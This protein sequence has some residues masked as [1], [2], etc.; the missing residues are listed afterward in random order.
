MLLPREWSVHNPL[1]S[2]TLKCLTESELKMILFTLSN[3]EKAVIMVW[4]KN[5]ES[6]QRILHNQD[7]AYLLEYEPVKFE[8]PTLPTN[9]LWEDDTKVAVPMAKLQKRQVGTGN[10]KFPRVDIRLPIEILAANSSFKSHTRDISEGGIHIED[11]LPAWVAGYF[12]VILTTDLGPLE[13][14]CMIV[15][16]QNHE[17]RRIGIVSLEQEEEE[18]G[19]TALKDWLNLKIGMNQGAE[20]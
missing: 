8:T 10:R 1:K 11:P 12:P 14:N 15:E 18:P 17:K 7:L 2:W 9:L 4:H 3:A 19:L 13:V 6:W 5:W 20:S 16:D